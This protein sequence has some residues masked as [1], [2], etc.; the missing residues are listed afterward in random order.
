MS[1]DSTKPTCTDDDLKRIAGIKD[2][3]LAGQLG[4]LLEAVHQIQQTLQTLP[5]QHDFAA[6]QTD[7]KIIKAAVTDTSQQVHDHERRITLVEA[8]A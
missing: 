8:Q 3:Q 1:N 7:V 5:T 2:E 4:P 6:T